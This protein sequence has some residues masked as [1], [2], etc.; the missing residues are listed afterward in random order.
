MLP[1]IFR[2]GSFTLYTYGIFLVLAFF[3]FLYLVWKS[4]RIT[5][6]K[7]YELFDKIFLSLGMGL[8]VGR[9]AYM[10]FHY[11]IILKKGYMAFLAVHLY[12][13]FHGFT[14]ILIATLSLYLFIRDKKYSASEIWAHSIPAICVAMAII[15]L[16]EV[17]SG[18]VV[19]VV[20]DFPIRVKYA[21]YD[22]LRHVP[23]LYRAIVFGFMSYGFHK[24]V[25]L[26]RQNKISYGMIVT[27]FLWVFAL[28]S[29][30]IIPISDMPTYGLSSNYRLYDIYLGVITLLTSFGMLVYHWR[31]SLFGVIKLSIFSRSH[32]HG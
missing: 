21:L 23:T 6:Y 20:T 30:M 14:V 27:I 12:P 26:A 4:I 17:F 3:W 10:V 9:I 5:S 28:T 7:E 15:N 11:D 25:L 16:G 13:G 2:F 1:V 18:S 22:G 8:L 31:S 19:G 29:I 24:M 32:T